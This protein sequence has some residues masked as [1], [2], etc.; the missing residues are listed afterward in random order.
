M[1]KTSICFRGAKGYNWYQAYKEKGKDAF[2]KHVP[3]TVFNWDEP[4]VMRKRAF[5]DLA[6]EQ[7]LLGRLTFELA[8]DIVP[9]TVENFLNLCNGSGKFS[10]KG[11]KFHDIRKGFTI[12]GG[13]VEMRNGK[14]GHSSFQERYFLDEN[15]IIPCMHRGLI[16]MASIGVNSNNSQFYISLDA[17]PH[18]LGRS[19]VFG[20]VIGG[21]DIIKTIENVSISSLLKLE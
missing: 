3:P 8:D 10:Y 17:A 6:V 20:R 1:R 18:L 2:R 19:V 15:F 7:D 11:T 16:S 5:F 14:G 9:K 21:D 13:D 12:M 4:K